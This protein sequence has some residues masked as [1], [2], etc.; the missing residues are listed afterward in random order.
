ML[1]LL[2]ALGCEPVDPAL[3]AD[4]QALD[5]SAAGEAALKA[6]D[7]AGATEAFARAEAARP[8][9]PVLVAW[10]AK[11]LADQGRLDDAV[12]LLGEVLVKHPDFAIARY[13]RAAWLA[14]AGKPEP[15]AAELR[16]ALAD[17]AV[18][19]RD[20]LSDADFAPWLGHPAFAFLPRTPLI[21]SVDAPVGPL[22]WG[23][24]A[25]IQLRIAGGDELA[26]IR[27][28]GAIGGPIAL[29]SPVEEIRQ[30]T[31]GRVHDLAWPVRALGAGDAVI[32]PFTVSVG[33]AEATTEIARFACTA[34]P[35]RET[36]PPLP[37]SIFRVP[38]AVAGDHPTPSAW[39]ADG[40]LWAKVEAADRVALS[41]DPGGP[42]ERLE[43]REAGRTA[44]LV[45]GWEAAAAGTTV[46]V[47]RAGTSVFEGAP[48]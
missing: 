27:V 13:D 18:R 48:Q 9:D 38:S 42:G 33:A 14:R 25:R 35:G 6:G 46:R 10:R 24:E 26:P 19:P 5:A 8:G 22:F 41:P 1:A 20:V 47:T 23:S 16:R 34:P 3:V 30:S 4:R 28:D 44:W 32:G 17:G 11:A 40:W 12:D 7:P 2:L 31:D 29:G 43:L 21:V 45:L 15:A 39:R 37:S 36:P